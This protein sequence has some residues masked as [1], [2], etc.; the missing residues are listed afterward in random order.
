MLDMSLYVDD[1]YFGAKDD[2]EAYELSRDAAMILKAAGMNLR[3]LNTNCEKLRS[4]WIQ[5]GLVRNDSGS[6]GQLKVLGLN[7]NMVKD[8][9]S[10]DVTSL[11]KSLK[12]LLST[13][14]F[15]LHAASMVFDSVGFGSPFVVRIKCLLQ[16]I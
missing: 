5:Q 9:L 10:L 16:E 13:K 12:N 4:M 2:Y 14:R 3:K 1:L 15:V 11:L 7:W 8:E 6:N